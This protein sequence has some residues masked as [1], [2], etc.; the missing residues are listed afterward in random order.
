LPTQTIDDAQKY[1]VAV[2]M[3]T[4]D[5]V[6]IARE[7]ARVLGMGDYIKTSAGL[8]MLDPVTKRKPANL[9]RDYGDMC[10]AVDGFAQVTHNQ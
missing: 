1:G 8:P 6:L 5:H 4:G 9:G 3:I 7:T 2:K 10:L